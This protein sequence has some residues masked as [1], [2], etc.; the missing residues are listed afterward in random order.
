MWAVPRMTP[1]RTRVK[2]SPGARLSFRRSDQVVL[3]A[4]AVADHPPHH[5]AR[6]DALDL[7]VVAADQGEAVKRQAVDEAHK[8][9]AQV[10]HVLVVVQVVVVDIGD[11]GDGGLQ[12]QEAGEGLAG[13]GHEVVALAQAGVAAAQ[14]VQH[15]AD[16]D[17][18]VQ[19]ALGQHQ[20]G[21]AGGGGLAVGA[22][23]AD[24][25]LQAHQLVE[26]LGARDHRDLAAAGLHQ[27]RVGLRHGIG[28][29]HALGRAHVGGGVPHVDGGA[30]APEALHRVAVGPV[31]TRHGIAQGQQHLG[32]AAHARASDPHEVEL[33]QF[34]E[35][36]CAPQ[37]GGPFPVRHRLRPRPVCPGYARPRP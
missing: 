35:H 28:N 6:Q 33:H 11:H 7:R 25:V 37:D 8:G 29:D 18:G 30:Q 27:L 1:L 16:D 31:G 15:A 26:H 22:G 24:P 14:G 13:L 20:R 23:D 3:L 9:V 12:L 19:A 34:V 36:S 10:V 32:D 21:H 4:E 5:P 17:G 2:R